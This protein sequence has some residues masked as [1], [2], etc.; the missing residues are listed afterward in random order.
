MELTTTLT[1]GALTT[2]WTDRS[3]PFVVA[4]PCSAE[5]ADQVMETALA[6]KKKGGV[7]LFRAG[8]WK[9]R[10]SPGNF[11]GYGPKALPW[12]AAAKAA[13]GLPMGVE[14]AM[15]KHIDL[16]LAHNVDVVWLGARTTVNPFYVQELAEA[17]RGV[18]IP[19]MVKNPINPQVGLWAGAIER[20]TQCGVKDIVNI[21]R[22]FSVNTKSQFRNAPLWEIPEAMQARFPGIPMISDPSHIAGKRSLIAELAQQTAWQAMDGLMVEVHPN[23]GEALSDA[24][25]QLTPEDFW[26]VI[27]E[28]DWRIPDTK[29]ASLQR[30][31]HE[32]D[33]LDTELL[34]LLA[35]RAALAKELGAIKQAK[36]WPILQSDR[37]QE[38]LNNRIQQGKNL[39]LS[40][41]FVRDLF[42][43]I[44]RESL[45][46]QRLGV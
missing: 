8:I 7:H 20:L 11:E 18:D 44:H 35:R 29:Q 16:C 41:Q 17:L 3:E 26:Q 40:E 45:A 37:W 38:V 39:A 30:Q 24:K 4:G 31:R 32:I 19:V 28:L 6:L 36:G 15:P 13:T 27:E 2:I 23:P 1:T 12:L 5:S 33:A 34:Q 9:P 42:K 25:Q 43:E 22:G 14:V 10:T 21:H 46:I